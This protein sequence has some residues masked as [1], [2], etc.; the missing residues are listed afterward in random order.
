METITFDYAYE[1]DH[2]TESTAT[3][4]FSSSGDIREVLTEFTFFLRSIGFDYVTQVTAHSVTHDDQYAYE[5][6][7]S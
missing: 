5:G 3:R 1:D 6:D 2:G 7:P 4:K